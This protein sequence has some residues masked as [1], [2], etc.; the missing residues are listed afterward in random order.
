M[1]RVTVMYTASLF[2]ANAALGVAASRHR[3]TVELQYRCTQFTP[4]QVVR[5]AYPYISPLRML[6]S[7][8]HEPMLPI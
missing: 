7:Y 3:T 8:S 4:A 1:M 2:L 5:A 6:C